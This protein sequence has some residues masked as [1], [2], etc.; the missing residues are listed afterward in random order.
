MMDIGIDKM[1]FATT[2]YYLDLVDLAKARKV[3]PN[4]YL[5]GIGQSKQ[6]VVPASQDVVTIGAAAAEKLLTPAL[7]KEITSVLVATESGID[8]SKAV[9][10]Y[11]QHLL[12]LSAFVRV[13]EIKQACYGGTAALMMARGLVAANPQ[14]K[15]LVIASDIARYGLNTPGEVTQGAGAVAMI[16]SSHPHVLKLGQTS[17]AYSQDIM[18]FWR[19]LYSENAMVDGHYSTQVFIDFFKN[20]FSHYQQQTGCQLADFSAI[21]THLPFT[22]MAT[23]GLNG[24]LGERQD[25]VATTLRQSLKASQVYS[26]IVGNLYTGSLYLGLLSYLENGQPKSG[27]LIGL[28]SYGSG[29]AGEFFTARLVDGYQDYINDVRTDLAKRQQ[30]S[31]SQY[32]KMFK[33]QLGLQ[34]A[35]V[36]FDISHDHSRVVMK[37][38]K[39][40][41]THYPTRK[42]LNSAK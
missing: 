15:V 5:I 31:V 29:A 8:N 23:K 33:Q 6:A 35:D 2:N 32:E 13:A 18:D 37:T 36:T 7:K 25:E 17:V 19:P 38:P 27:E 16:V 24:L 26:R 1:A 41:K 22:K 34:N 10:T 4:K 40:K 3:D 30:V 21:L 14:E 12:G 39:K 20:C 42:I 9:A 28:F 11:I